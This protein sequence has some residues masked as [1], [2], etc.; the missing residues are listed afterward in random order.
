MPEHIPFSAAVRDQPRS[1]RTAVS[2]IRSSLADARIAP[3]RRE[4]T[5]AVLAMG[6]S[7]NSAHAL[8]AALA[9]HGV[10]GANLAASEVADY[11]DGFEPGDHYLLITE[12]GRSPEPIAAARGRGEGRRIAIT[13]YPGAAV[14]EVAD[15]TIGYCGIH[16]S[17][18][19]TAGYLATLASYAAVMDAAG[20]PSGFD[21]DGLP[22]LVERALARYSPVAVELAERFDGARAAD[23]IGRGFGVSSAMQ[24]ALLFREALRLNASGFE[25]Y[26][27]LHGPVESAGAGTVLIVI[28]DGRELD[29]V[30]QAAE[31]G[32]Q[33]I[34]L[35]A[36]GP[37]RPAGSEHGRV[38]RVD[39]ADTAAGFERTVVET[40][41]LQLLAEA[42]AERQGL[43]IEEFLYDQPDTK[44]PEA[45]RPAP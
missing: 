42:V 34:V 36:A 45:G 3:W 8:V 38:A 2:H 1:L 10:R 16:D 27:Y 18:V 44:L 31:G 12:S 26:Q 37:D 30:P 21:I 15:H 6:A 17:P 32:A 40:V 4:E 7:T 5:V 13:N 9:E 33:V 23:L 41:I 20:L 25:T 28:G 11:P 14:S 22:Q 19:Y 29:L 35:S 43:V 39:L 24:G